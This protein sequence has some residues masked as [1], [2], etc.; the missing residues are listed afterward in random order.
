MDFSRFFAGIFLISTTPVYPH[1]TYYMPA[2]YLII[3]FWV[4]IIYFILIRFCKHYLYIIGMVSII[5]L[6]S[7]YYDVTPIK[8]L[9][10]RVPKGMLRGFAYM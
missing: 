7:L 1:Y 9:F 4:S 6:V 5:I 8:H 3:L 2:W 10:S